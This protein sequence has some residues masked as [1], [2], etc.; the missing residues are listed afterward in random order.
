[1]AITK[2]DVEHVAWL[3]RLALTDE[4]KDMFTRQLSQILEHAGKIAELDTSKI[5]PTSHVLP[6]KNVFRED[7]TRPC[8]SREEALSNAPAKER[9]MLKIPKII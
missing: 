2:K 5:L 6:V 8:L 1:M 3:A 7:E 4:E 9:G